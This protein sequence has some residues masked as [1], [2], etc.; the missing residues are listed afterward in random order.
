M[1]ASANH[2]VHDLLWFMPETLNWK[3]VPP[4]RRCFK[5]DVK[6]VRILMAKDHNAAL[7]LI[8]PREMNLSLWAARD[9]KMRLLKRGSM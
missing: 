7:R 2:P 4:R 8:S 3:K 1:E 9:F 5:V 6:D